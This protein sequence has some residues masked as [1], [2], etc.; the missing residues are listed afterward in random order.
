MLRDRRSE[1]S[2][3]WKVLGVS[4]REREKEELEI[5]AKDVRARTPA[6]FPESPRQEH[7][8]QLQTPSPKKNHGFLDAFA[9][10]VRA[11]TALAIFLLG[12]QQLSGIDGV[13][14]VS[15]LKS[16]SLTLID[17]STH[18]FC[19]HKLVSRLQRRHFSL[20]VF[21]QSLFSA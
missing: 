6:T 19:L 17:S 3:V 12:M 21:L 10:D 14:Y 8:S 9:R 18:L 15:V 5:Q 1:A 13:L 2:E 4:Q 16:T 11:R 20:L 7:T